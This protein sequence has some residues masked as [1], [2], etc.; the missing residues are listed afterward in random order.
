MN[1]DLAVSAIKQLFMKH[2]YFS[3]IVSVA[4]VMAILM[5]CQENE[6]IVHMDALADTLSL[7]ELCEIK[8][9]ESQVPLFANLSDYDIIG[10]DNTRADGDE[11]KSLF[12]LLDMEDIR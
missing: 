8:I 2:I 10:K 6:A 7:Q 4:T 9:P 5:S 1:I 11:L 12:S 3:Y